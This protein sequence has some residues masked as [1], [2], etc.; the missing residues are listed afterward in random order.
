MPLRAD[1]HFFCFRL[2][3]EQ[4]ERALVEYQNKL[5][6]AET[7][8]ETAEQRVNTL[9]SNRETTRNETTLLRSEVA[10]LKKT[11]V[12]LENE[13]DKILVSNNFLKICYDKVFLT[14]NIF[15]YNLTLRLSVHISWNTS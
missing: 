6:I 2:L 9:D 8:L 3:H 4:T 7:H 12:N 10:A 11:Y 1:D 5:L 14:L 15:R 13:K